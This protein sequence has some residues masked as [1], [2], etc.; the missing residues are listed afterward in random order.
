[1]SVVLIPRLN[2]NEDELLL[3]SLLVDNGDEVDVGDELAI[4]IQIQKLLVMDQ[5]MD[6]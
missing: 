4:L 1:M 5:Q 3:A 6:F 2:A